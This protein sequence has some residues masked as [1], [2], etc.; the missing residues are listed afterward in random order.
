MGGAV[1]GEHKGADS[2]PAF[3]VLFYGTKSAIT[4]PEHRIRSYHNATSCI[5]FFQP[6]LESA[7]QL[8]TYSH[9]TGTGSY[10][11]ICKVSARE[12]VL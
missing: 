8:L 4:E 3:W 6:L 7:V 10:K 9:P 5:H 11:S 12:V 1:S 2:S